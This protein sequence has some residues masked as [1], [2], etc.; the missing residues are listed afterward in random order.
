MK[1]SHLA[2]IFTALIFSSAC[3]ADVTNL[4]VSREKLFGTWSCEASFKENDIEI[5][6]VSDDTYVRNGS[7]NSF[8]TMTLQ[9]SKEAPPI[10]YSIASTG[11]W[12]IDSKFL[13]T[14]FTD[15]KIVNLSHPEFDKILNLQEMFPMNMSESAE[16][17]ELSYTTLSVKSESDGQRYNCTR[18]STKT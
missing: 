4:T 10:E 14:T 16:I 7:S 9:L 18:K 17:V 11:T 8:G 15:L 2:S 13:V 12:E 1:L 3:V 5:K 6:I